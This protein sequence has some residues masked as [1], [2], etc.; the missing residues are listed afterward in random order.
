MLALPNMGDS[1]IFLAYLGLLGTLIG[2]LV[3][4]GGRY[5]WKAATSYGNQED[6]QAVVRRLGWGGAAMGIGATLV[7]LGVVM[8][9]LLA[10]VL[11]Q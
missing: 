11:L 6:R 7:V 9:I 5:L 4:W 1:L 8:L 3:L 2:I 10:L